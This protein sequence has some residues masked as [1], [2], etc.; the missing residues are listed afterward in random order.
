MHLKENTCKHEQKFC[1]ACGEPFECKVG[2]IMHCQCTTVQLS[3]KERAYIAQQ[4]DDCLCAGC[5]QNLKTAY[6]NNLLKTKIKKLL[7]I[8][9]K[10]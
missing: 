9:E 5:M 4:Y 2:T 1:P 8:F 10:K 7:R 6:R 3:P